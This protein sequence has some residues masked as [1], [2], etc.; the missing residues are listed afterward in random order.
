MIECSPLYRSR[1]RVAQWQSS[2]LLSHW[3]RVRISPR[4]LIFNV[5]LWVAFLFASLRKGMAFKSAML[6]SSPEIAEQ[7]LDQNA[8]QSV[9]EYMQLP[10]IL[11]RPV[12]KVDLK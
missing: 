6:Q 9:H 3:L 1:G 5:T 12:Y 11:A 4:S 2:G 10:L 7:S 8:C